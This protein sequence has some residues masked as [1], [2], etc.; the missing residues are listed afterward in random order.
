MFKKAFSLPYIQIHVEITDF[1]YN[2]NMF[3]KN[4]EAEICEMLRIFGLVLLAIYES[5]CLG[6]QKSVL[7]PYYLVS[8]LGE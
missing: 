3:D 7:C 6:S 5:L 1:M 4:I 2:K 8:V